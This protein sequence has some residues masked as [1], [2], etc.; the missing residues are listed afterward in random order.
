MWEQRALAE[1]ELL[2]KKN[3]NAATELLTHKPQ[4][5][6]IWVN[7]GRSRKRNEIPGLR[8]STQ[9]QTE[10]FKVAVET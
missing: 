6:E 9:I 2:L 7:K 3:F 5:Q 8:R 10:I 1:K 4:S